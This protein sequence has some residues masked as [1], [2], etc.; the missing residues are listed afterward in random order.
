MTYEFGNYKREKECGM[1]HISKTKK[2]DEGARTKELREKERD[3]QPVF[4]AR[5]A[6]A[7]C[8]EALGFYGVAFSEMGK[9][10]DVTGLGLSKND[11]VLVAKFVTPEQQA[12]IAEN[13]LGFFA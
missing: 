1:Y 4:E 6:E 8:L 3:E 9:K 7:S 10:T 13:M 12:R 5:K 11:Q 2:V